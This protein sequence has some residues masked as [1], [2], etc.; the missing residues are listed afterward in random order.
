MEFYI[1]CKKEVFSIEQFEYSWKV[2]IHALNHELLIIGY[3]PSTSELNHDHGFGIEVLGN[4]IHPEKNYV[5][6]THSLTPQQRFKD[7]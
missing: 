6:T 2:W 5:E 7:A 4:V 1:L 3:S